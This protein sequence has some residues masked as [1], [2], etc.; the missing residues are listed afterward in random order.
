MAPSEY[1]P[2]V[3]SRPGA[4]ADGGPSASAAVAARPPD[5]RHA[6]ARRSAR[7]SAT[8]C[9]RVDE[10]RP[11]GTVRTVY[12]STRRIVLLAACPP[13]RSFGTLR[14]FPGSRE[15][16]PRVHTGG[17]AASATI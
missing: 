2:G 16:G 5:S 13:A 9:S 4:H 1:R 6:K 11:R 17:Q 10:S 8:G 12:P 14:L 15:A 7:L 3:A